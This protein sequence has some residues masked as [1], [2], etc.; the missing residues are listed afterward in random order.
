[1]TT[2]TTRD[3]YN[4]L[5]ATVQD[6]L[7]DCFIEQI[8]R[9]YSVFEITAEQLKLRQCQLIITNPKVCE[10]AGTQYVE[11]KIQISMILET[12]VNPA[13]G[14][15]SI[16]MVPLGKGKELAPNQRW[17]GGFYSPVLR[18]DQAMVDRGFITQR[19]LE[20]LIDYCHLWELNGNS[21]YQKGSQ[22]AKQRVY[23]TATR[24]DAVFQFDLTERAN[25]NNEL[26]PALDTVRWTQGGFGLLGTG[27]TGKAVPI[28]A[29]IQS[30]Q[31]GAAPVALQR[32]VANVAPAQVAA[33]SRRI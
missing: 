22:A 21:N 19:E 30:F 28:E 23:L 13:N 17:S 8:R 31:D 12:G 5:S 16:T 15:L 9:G 26:V 1:M 27:I 6:S 7:P 33:G 24:N 11:A 10:E 32:P 20:Q 25:S 18:F 4:A 2:Q 14:E 3:Q 29:A